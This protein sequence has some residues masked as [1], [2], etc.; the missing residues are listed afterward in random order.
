MNLFCYSGGQIGI[1]GHHIYSKC[2]SPDRQGPSNFTQA[3]DTQRLPPQ[4]ANLASLPVQ[5][6]VLTVQDVHIV[7]Q[8]PVQCQHQGHGV[9]GNLVC[10]VFPNGDHGNPLLRGTGHVHKVIARRRQR[11][12]PELLRTLQHILIHYDQASQKRVR[13][14]QQRFE[15]VFFRFVVIIDDRLYVRE[16]GPQQIDLII[17][18]AVLRLWQIGDQH[19][20][21]QFPL[22]S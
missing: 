13:V 15:F 6:P 17:N 4:A 8:L 12:N 7:L 16:S 11:Q 14:F 3:E 9:V 1:I 20:H 19:V 22:V 10:A 21:V 18:V 5:P 2:L